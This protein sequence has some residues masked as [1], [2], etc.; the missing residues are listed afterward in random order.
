[1]T[2][3]IEKL[4]DIPFFSKLANL[5][6]SLAMFS[7]I[8]FGAALILYF[9]SPK[10]N[11]AIQWLKVVL[12]ILFIDLLLLDLFGLTIYIPYRAENGPRTILK[13]SESLSWLHNIIF[14]HKEFL[15]FAPPVLILVALVIVSQLNKQF[16]DSKFKYLRLSVISTIILSLIFV[17]TVAGEAVLVTKAVP[18]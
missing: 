18:I 8:L 14:E 2:E 4:I 15:A 9:L 5:H 1:M 12:I 13:S 16:A 7:L 17:L 3:L 11:L 10:I 6:G